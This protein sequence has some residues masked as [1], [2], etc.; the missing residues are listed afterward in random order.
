L[1]RHIIE[2]L[3]DD[4]KHERLIGRLRELKEQVSHGG[5][6]E[7]ASEYILRVLG[8]DA[9]IATTSPAPVAHNRAA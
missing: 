9:R 5:A 2:W 8:G 4:A 7:R 1:A 6:S 3:T